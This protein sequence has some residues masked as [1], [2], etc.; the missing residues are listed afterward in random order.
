MSRRTAVLAIAA[1]F[2]ASA[3]AANL[4]AAVPVDQLTDLTGSAVTIVTLKARDNF[5]N[6]FQYDVTV[7]NQGSEPLVADSLVIVV[8]QITDLAGKDATDRIEVVGYDGQTPAGKPYYLVPPGSRPELPPFGQS[9]PA[10]VRLRN[11]YYTILFT[12]S[13]RVLGQR[14]PPPSS[15]SSESL[16]TLVQALIKKGVLT[17]EEW[18]RVLQPSSQPQP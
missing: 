7:K 8:D 9:E 14:R 1:V 13:F 17:L 4:P 12:P 6:E 11:P 18:L 3:G 15:P 5:A 16:T 2:A 10:S